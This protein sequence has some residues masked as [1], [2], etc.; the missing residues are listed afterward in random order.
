MSS[1]QVRVTGEDRQLFRRLRALGD[2]DMK[3]VNRAMAEALRTGTVERFQTEKTPEGGRWESSIRAAENGQK[4]LTQTG[5]LKRSI[6][7]RANEAGFAVGTNDIRAATLQFGDRRTIRARDGGRLIFRIG[8]Q[9]RR[10]REVTVTI[11]ARAFLGVSED[12]D[13]EIRSMLESMLE[14]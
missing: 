9:W 10:A 1:I 7:V 8:G 4:T 6:R 11:P 5:Q 13:A 14:E 2:I 3:G 12:D